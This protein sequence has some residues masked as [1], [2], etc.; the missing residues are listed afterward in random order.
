MHTFKLAS[1]QYD[2]GFFEHWDEFARKLDD[3]VSRAARQGA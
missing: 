3:W 2:I 1:A